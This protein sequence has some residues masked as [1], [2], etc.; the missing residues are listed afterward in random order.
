MKT[1]KQLGLKALRLERQGDQLGAAKVCRDASRIAE[2]EE[3]Y[4]ICETRH[5][6]SYIAGNSELHSAANSNTVH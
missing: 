3:A 4:S 2:T 1:C 5:S 6:Q